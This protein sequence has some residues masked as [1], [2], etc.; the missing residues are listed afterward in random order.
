MKKIYHFCFRY[1]RILDSTES[2]RFRLVVRL[3]EVLL[4][5]RQAVFNEGKNIYPIR[6]ALIVHCVGS[7]VKGGF[8]KKVKKSEK[9][10]PEIRKT[11]E[12]KGFLYKRFS[13]NNQKFRIFTRFFPDFGYF[14]GKSVRVFMPSAFA[15]A[16][17]LSFI[18]G[19]FPHSQHSIVWCG[20][21]L[22]IAISRIVNPFLSRSSRSLAANL[23]E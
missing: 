9:N 16:G 2:T 17:N 14:S 10:T 1:G 4:T 15:R 13:E 18:A 7:V 8:G 21:P 6:Y 22:S 12:N 23:P 3:A 19:R 11:L 5:L 20:I